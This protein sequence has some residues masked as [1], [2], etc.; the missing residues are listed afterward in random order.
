MAYNGKYQIGKNKNFL[1]AL[2]HA[3]DGIRTAILEERNMKKHLISAVIAMIMG[4]IFRLRLSEWLWLSLAIFA[5][6]ISEMVNTA[7]ENVVDLIVGPHYHELAKKVKDMAAGV[8]LLA[9]VFA[10]V[11]GLFLFLPK[12]ELLLRRL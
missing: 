7:F 6:I 11:I 2:K 9:S 1:T 5:V 8:V 4:L 3:V 12:L 10:V